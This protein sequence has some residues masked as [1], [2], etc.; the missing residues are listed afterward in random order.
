[1]MSARSHDSWWKSEPFDDGVDTVVVEPVV[2]RRIELVWMGVTLDCAAPP[3]TTD[4]NHNPSKKPNGKPALDGTCTG[5]TN[6]LPYWTNGNVP[7]VAL[8]RAA[9]L[10]DRMDQD[11][12]LGG[13]LLLPSARKSCWLPA[14]PSSACAAA[15]RSVISCW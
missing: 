10:T 4:H 14:A 11:L 12:N 5:A 13:V 1:M 15:L 3:A 6:W 7:L 9:N 2:D 8:L